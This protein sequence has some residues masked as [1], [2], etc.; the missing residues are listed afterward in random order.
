MCIIPR[1]PAI[2]KLPIGIQTFQKIREDDYVYVD[3]TGIAV[4]LINRYQYVFLS[5]CLIAAPEGVATLEEAVG[6]FM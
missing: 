6:G 1:R 4:D 5:I 3:K 2:K